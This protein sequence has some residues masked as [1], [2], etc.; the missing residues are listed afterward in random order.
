MVIGFTD[1]FHAGNV[2][3]K[4]STV[5]VARKKEIASPANEKFFRITVFVSAKT[6]ENLFKFAHV[7]VFN[8]PFCLYVH[9]KSVVM[10]KRK[11]F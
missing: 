11:V 4:N 5:K 7:L 3:V 9:G 2:S 6:P 1:Y 8:K 10:Q